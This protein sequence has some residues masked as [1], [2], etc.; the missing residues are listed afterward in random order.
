MSD[1]TLTILIISAVVIGIGVALWLRQ[2]K[3]QKRIE[4]SSTVTVYSDWIQYAANGARVC[5]RSG[6]SEAFLATVNTVLNELFLDA[7]AQGYTQWLSGSSYTIYVL[8]GC[9]P[10]PEQGI[11]SFKI[12]ADNYDGTVFDQDPRPGIGYVLASEYVILDANGAP[13]G[14]YV[15]C[16]SDAYREANIENGPDHII[17]YYNDRQRYEETK[18]HTATSG[19]RIIPRRRVSNV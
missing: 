17:L 8:D 11:P 3:K 10:S 2:R 14:E 4:E 1:V 13:T 15:I 19:H 9:P 7:A 18:T 6:K 5:S 16:D 12:R